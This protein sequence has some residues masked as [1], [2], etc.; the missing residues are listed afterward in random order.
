MG[1]TE[2]V[3]ADD[4]VLMARWLQAATI[5]DD[6]ILML[7]HVQSL[8]AYCALAGMPT[9]AKLYRDMAKRLNRSLQQGKNDDDNVRPI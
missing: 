8:A 2:R 6:K 3:T 1:Q 9:T 7:K 5:A 4:F